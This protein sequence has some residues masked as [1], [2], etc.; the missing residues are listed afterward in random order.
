M[1]KT[2]NSFSSILGNFS[3]AQL[4]ALELLDGIVQA[5]GSE[6]KSIT[7]D[8][9]TLDGE[10][11]TYTIPSFGYLETRLQRFE[12][13]IE[14]LMG[15]D[16]S[17]VN[18]R[19]SDGTYRK[20]IQS[21]LLR[22][23]ER[24]KELEVPSTFN[25]RNNWF[26]EDFL[27]PALYFS[28]DVS[29]YVDPEADKILVKRVILNTETEDEIE[30]FNQTFNGRNDISY[31]DLIVRLTNNNI[32]FFVDEEVQDLPLSVVRYQG[33]FDVYR[34]ED[35][36]VERNGE[37]VKRRKYFLNKITYTDVLNSV[38]DT[39]E[40]KTKDQLAVGESIYEIESINTD[41]RSI[42][43]KR[44]SGVDTIGIGADVLRI[45][46]EK[47]STKVA[48]VGIGFDER[49]V[50][51]FKSVDPNFNVVSIDWSDGI[52]FYSNELEIE[53][54]NGT[55]TLE[56]FYRSEVSDFGQQFIDA[57]KD[58]KIPAIFGEVP[59]PPELNDNDFSVV[60]INE[61]KLDTDEVDD[62]L[63]KGKEKVRLK[64]EI[65]EIERE[66]E[67]K[68]DELI[69]RNFVSETERRG[70]Q[71]EQLDLIRG[72]TAKSNLYASIIEE[73]AVLS[74]DKPSV[75][76]K[77][78]F[79]IR[80]FFEIP[81]P[82]IVD[83]TGP[84]E[85]VQ[86]IVEYR[87]VR[88]DGSATDN[89]QFDFV[90]SEGQINRGT[91]SNWTSVKSET[92]KKEFNPESGLY[93][94]SD[95]NT[96]DPNV[97]NIN[98]IDIPISKGERVEIRI[99]SVSEAGYPVN[100]LTSEYSNVVSIDF[101][102]ELLTEDEATN[103]IE[104]AVDER[105]RV[106]FQRELDTR[107]LDLHLSRAFTTGDKY[108]AHD[109]E[110]IASGFFTNEG[111]VINM[112]QKIKELE[113]ELDTLK[114]RIEEIKG[115]LK[116]TIIDD[117]G[118][119]FVV[120][121]G[122]QIDLFAGY[123]RDFTNELPASE[124]KGAIINREYKLLIENTENAPLELISRLPGGLGER[125]PS[126]V[127]VS[128]GNPNQ[129]GTDLG[130]VNEAISPKDTEYNNSRRYDIVPIVNNSIDPSETTNS[131]KITSSLHQSQQNP[132][133]F[134]YLRHTDIGLKQKSGD[135][136]Y[137]SNGERIDKRLDGNY[138]PTKRSYFPSDDG[139][140]NDETADFVWDYINGYDSNDAPFGDGV[141]SRFAIHVDHPVINDGLTTSFDDLQNP[142]IELTGYIEDE[143]YGNIPVTDEDEIL[144]EFRQS[145]GLNVQNLPS[146]VPNKNKNRLTT[147]KYKQLNYRNN[148]KEL[149]ENGWENILGDDPADINYPLS[150][151]YDVTNPDEYILPD[152]YGFTDND[153]YLIGIDTC[154]SYFY[155]SPSTINQLFVDGTDNRAGKFISSGE[156]NGIEI[157]MIFQFRMTDYFGEGNSGEGIVGGYNPNSQVQITPEQK[158]INLTYKR[159]LGIDL[160]LRNETPF[161]FDV[162]VTGKFKRESL[163]QKTDLIGRRVSKSREN[164]IIKKS[165]LKSIK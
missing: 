147:Q 9:P 149:G 75:L 111:N 42:I 21:R 67:K 113:T 162:T 40:L 11:V 61:H 7:L 95:E 155:L 53:T 19:M 14:K 39:N 82:I 164:L 152:K 129:F 59:N 3:R 157:P 5:V 125:L 36:E 60:R 97:I 156:G 23:P 68:K 46:S 108:F 153:R 118:N 30:F 88:L 148:W 81:S 87:Y 119:K 145:F 137:D 31:Q 4:Q 93:E 47:F 16:G 33:T 70:V 131:S 104:Q 140:Q 123:Y 27:N 77:P 161:S 26:F 25:Y 100:P 158:K 150:I 133:Q 116:V 49:Q 2:K 18:I 76:D 80:G 144:S 106:A 62:I 105:S 44:T 110:Q 89:K 90:D 85:I 71:N 99:K 142:E 124:R 126:T 109:A 65:R 94:W 107:G 86:F 92:R 96:E 103:I 51:F 127:D 83:K 130:W 12:N 91:Y 132:S 139:E 34:I 74:Q 57:A 43:V 56:R 24:I 141:L 128:G 160:Y 134:L 13:T 143:L 41:E 35:V 159:R 138:D 38:N 73:L 165:Q 32:S 54:S 154:G 78:K 115:E 98:Q 63:E 20:L 29:R 66:I 151:T 55:R 135:L 121:N 114:S 101:P 163:A 50:V 15:T 28:T 79:R 69:N 8:F 1:A 17:D 64:S 84:Q 10:E 45:Y 146:S 122:D 120:N 48:K 72:K 102:E 112:F 117:E 52:A 22:S 58:P 6:K 37:T 136:Y